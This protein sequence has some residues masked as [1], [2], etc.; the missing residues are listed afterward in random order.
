MQA[1]Y[2]LPQILN[3][4][5]GKSP[6]VSVVSG[7]FPHTFFVKLGH[8]STVFRKILYCT[9]IGGGEGEGEVAVFNAKRWDP[10]SS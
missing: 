7:G 3:V 8:S 9:G 6:F 4:H 10:R 1:V 2:Y 5:E